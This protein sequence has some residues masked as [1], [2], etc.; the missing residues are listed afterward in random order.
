MKNARSVGEEPATEADGRGRLGLADLR[1][2]AAPASQG[3]VGDLRSGAEAEAGPGTV[4]TAGDVQA[5]RSRDGAAV[6]AVLSA[7]RGSHGGGGAKLAGGEGVGGV[8]KK[9]GLF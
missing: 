4:R 1:P 6:L 8:E 2:G 3:R 9:M 7:G 5:A